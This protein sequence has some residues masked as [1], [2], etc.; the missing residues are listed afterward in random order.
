MYYDFKSLT[1]CLVD[2]AHH[3][4]VI[5]NLNNQFVLARQLTLIIAE[6]ENRETRNAVDSDEKTP[7]LQFVGDIPIIDLMTC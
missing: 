2:T 7:L 6:E 3:T 5:V 4:L 1:F